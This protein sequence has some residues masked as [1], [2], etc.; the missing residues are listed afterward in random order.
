MLKKLLREQLKRQNFLNQLTDK[1]GDEQLAKYYLDAY[2]DSLNKVNEH[3]GEVFRLA[4]TDNQ[5]KTEEAEGTNWVLSKESLRKFL[6][7]STKTIVKA[8]VRPGG[9]DMERSL[10]KYASNPEQDEVV[11]VHPPE[12]KMTRLLSEQEQSDIAKKVQRIN[13]FVLT[14][15]RFQSYFSNN[16]ERAAEYVQKLGMTSYFIQNMVG[17]DSRYVD[18]IMF[19]LTQRLLDPYL[20]AGG[21]MQSWMFYYMTGNYFQQK[22]LPKY[23][24]SIINYLR[25]TG[26]L[27]SVLKEK[28]WEDTHFEQ[29]FVQYLVAHNKLSKD[30]IWGYYTNY[31]YFKLFPSTAE[32]VDF[33]KEKGLFKRA[34][35]ALIHGG[36]AIS[37][38]ASPFMKYLMEY[39]PIQA[40]KIVIQSCRDLKTVGGRTYMI[41]DEREDLASL[42]K[43]EAQVK[44]ILG[45]DLD[46]EPYYSDSFDS[47][48][49]DNL[50]E[51]ALQH[52]MGAILK[53]FENQNIPLDTGDFEVYHDEDVQSG[54][55]QDDDEGFILTKERLA[56]IERD[57]NLYDLINEADELDDIKNNLIWASDDAQN[58]ALQGEYYNSVFKEIKDVFGSKGEEFKTGV[59]TKSEHG[60]YDEWKYRIEVDGMLFDT[61]STY[62]ENHEWDVWTFFGMVK[63]NLADEDGLLSVYYP[64]YA[65]VS[66]EDYSETVLNRD[67]D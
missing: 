64:D 41:L 17:G 13:D 28:M 57:G 11:L 56:E 42:F 33:L 49:I 18:N 44:E 16:I 9:V 58:M 22:I 32:W 48:H 10:E 34:V 52:V 25:S 35:N 3:G 43:D 45:D 19:A 38:V 31:E 50:N 20:R 63:E 2:C 15:E 65:H 24:D 40:K 29:E 66:D 39:S 14:R 53:K 21:Q 59:K 6:G 54:K 37:E 4:F 1:Y 8:Y 7:A 23:G 61:V 60:E 12:I 67:F 26:H 51:K 30:R 46:W 36:G 27:N 55:I 62:L 5:D 47:Y